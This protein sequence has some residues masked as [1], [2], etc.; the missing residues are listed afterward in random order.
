[1]SIE[2]YGTR[3]DTTHI[4][5]AAC[6]TSTTSS[7]QHCC[8]CTTWLVWLQ[9]KEQERPPQPFPDYIDD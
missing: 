2:S 1:M 3:P 6:E 9:E 7:Q 4:V 5:E 8:H